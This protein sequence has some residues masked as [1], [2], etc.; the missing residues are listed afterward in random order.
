M[1]LSMLD[2]VLVN[3]NSPGVVLVEKIDPTNPNNHPILLV[4]SIIMKYFALV[5]SNVK[6]YATRNYL[7]WS[8][9]GGNSYYSYQ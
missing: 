8:F 7:C 5:V 6:L 9:G 3:E 4:C 2:A 1:D